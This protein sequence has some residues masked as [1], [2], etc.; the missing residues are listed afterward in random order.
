FGAVLAGG[1]FTSINGS[2]QNYIALLACDG[3]SAEFAATPNGPV[4][5]IVVQP[6]G[7]I[8]IGGGFTMANGSP[9]TRLARLNADG[10]LDPTF[11]IAYPGFDDTVRSIALQSDGKVVVAGDFIH[12]NGTSR[13]YVARLNTNGTLDTTFVAS[14]SGPVYRV[15]ASGNLVT[16]GGTFISVGGYV[17]NRLAKLNSDGSVNTTFSPSSAPNSVVNTVLPVGTQT[18]AG[19]TFTSPRNRGAVYDENGNLTLGFT[20]GGMND[21]VRAM[22]LDN[23]GKVM[24]GGYFTWADCCTH[25]KIIRVDTASGS[26]ETSFDSGY[27][28]GTGTSVESISVQSDGKVLIGGNFSDVQGIY[29]HNIARLLPDRPVRVDTYL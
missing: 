29:R 22:A 17:R 16:I 13:Y 18:Y 27:I 6:D 1:D 24:V 15:A 23:F 14:P 5:S 3:S 25:Y 12:F 11:A 7:K 21:E 8:L 28:S 10:T 26:A 4:Y 9:C 2:A 19:G 20:Q